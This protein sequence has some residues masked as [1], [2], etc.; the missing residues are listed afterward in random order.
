MVE[1]LKN[2]C[3]AKHYDFKITV[4]FDVIACSIVVSKLLPLDYIGLYIQKY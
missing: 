3:I 1:V 4:S 2:F